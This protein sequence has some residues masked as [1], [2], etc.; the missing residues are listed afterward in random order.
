MQAYC[1]TAC[2]KGVVGKLRNA[3]SKMRNDADLSNRHTT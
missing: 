3:D 2:D 1:M